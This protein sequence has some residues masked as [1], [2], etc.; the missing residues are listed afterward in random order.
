MYELKSNLIKS[1]RIRQS[2]VRRFLLDNAGFSRE[3]PALSGTRLCA[4]YCRILPDSTVVAAQLTRALPAQYPHGENPAS[5]RGTWYE[6]ILSAVQDPRA[7]VANY[8][9]TIGCE[10]IQEISARRP[11]MTG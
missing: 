11:W 3:Y 5:A 6:F 1:G 4:G 8:W 7:S 10:V 2:L 9:R